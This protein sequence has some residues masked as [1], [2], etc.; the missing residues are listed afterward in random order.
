MKKIFVLFL[1][2]VQ[3]YLPASNI[4]FVEKKYNAL[5]I[6]QITLSYRLLSLS[7]G[8]AVAKAT[9]SSNIIALLENVDATLQNTQTFLSTD[10]TTTH[11]FTKQTQELIVHLLS[12][13]T[14]I[15]NYA[16]KKD[17]VSLNGMNSC[18]EK[19]EKEIL[20]LSSKFNKLNKNK[21]K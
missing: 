2:F 3:F 9:D 13:S 4:S 7:A 12:C 6:G 11:S 17:L 16:D 18:V 20:D 8:L 5:T 19:L 14:F 15:K 1:V 10:K 21:K